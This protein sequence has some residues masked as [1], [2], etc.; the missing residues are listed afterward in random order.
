[1][2]LWGKRSLDCLVATN[3]AVVDYRSV[4]YLF[5]NWNRARSPYFLLPAGKYLEKRR[6]WSGCFFLFSSEQYWCKSSAAKRKNN[7]SEHLENQIK[8]L[9]SHILTYQTI[10]MTLF[11]KPEKNRILVKLHAFTKTYYKII[12]RHS[13]CDPAETNCSVFDFHTMD[14]NTGQIPFLSFP[15]NPIV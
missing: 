2:R 15:M 13:L 6:C 7:L 12:I 1:M 5:I 3:L 10:S 8:T 4:I 14:Q 9:T 11:F